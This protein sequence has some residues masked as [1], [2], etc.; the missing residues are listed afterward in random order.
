MGWLVKIGL[1]V[2]LGLMIYAW[3]KRPQDGEV[4]IGLDRVA[5]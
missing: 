2:L 5:D 1:A 4:P 3:L